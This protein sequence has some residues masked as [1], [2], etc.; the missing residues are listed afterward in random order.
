MIIAFDAD[1]T[2]ENLSFAWVD[3]LNKKYGTN[4][5]REE[6][7][8]WDTSKF[9]PELR[10][11]QVYE[12]LLLS[13]F[14]DTVEPYADAQA[15]ISKL[16]D[17]GHD[18]YIVTSSNYQSF[19][20]KAENLIL[21]YFTVDWDHV[22]V[23]Y[24]K[25]LIKADVLVDDGVHNLIG[26]DYYKILMDAPYNQGNFENIGIHRARDF[27]EVYEMIH[28][29]SARGNETRCIGVNHAKKKI[30]NDLFTKEK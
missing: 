7:A 16:Q 13:E 30:R 2:I 23:T 1:D 14:W 20:A 11:E 12:P 17:E 22:I 24:N 5:K 9:F 25:Q 28:S 3:W 21:K 15:V 27:V 26:G 8:D 4:V 10:K 19:R 6:L 18:V 29:L